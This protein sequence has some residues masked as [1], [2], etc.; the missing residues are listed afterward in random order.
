MDMELKKFGSKLSFLRKKAGYTQTTL[1]KAIG[2]SRRT[3]AY[4]EKEASQPPIQLLKKL[5]KVFGLQVDE[6][7]GNNEDCNDSLKPRSSRLA[8]RMSQIERLPP[9]EKRQLLQIID[10]YID[11]DNLS[12]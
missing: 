3:I 4:Y 2:T 7:L 8:R 12:K 5:A 6:L 1:G 10:A 9:Q 11:R